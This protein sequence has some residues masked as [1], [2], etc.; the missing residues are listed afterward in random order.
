MDHHSRQ[1][2]TQK[3][4]RCH[5]DAP[6]QAV[7]AHNFKLKV[8]RTIKTQRRH[9]GSTRTTV[10]VAVAMASE[11]RASSALRASASHKGIH[12]SVMSSQDA[13]TNMAMDTV[14]RC[15]LTGDGSLV[16]NACI[17]VNAPTVGGAL[18]DRRHCSNSRVARSSSKLRLSI[19][20]AE[21]ESPAVTDSSR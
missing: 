5:F 16:C 3:Q 19:T 17:W 13:V 2:Q 8:I 4:V 9:A 7:K 11:S 14:S 6:S 1:R 21:S 20:N 12:S 10:A 18:Y 15:K